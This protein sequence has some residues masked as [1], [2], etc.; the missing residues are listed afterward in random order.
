MSSLLSCRSP[1]RGNLNRQT[2]KQ[3]RRGASNWLDRNGL[4]RVSKNS[5]A[6]LPQSSPRSKASRETMPMSHCKLQTIA[7]RTDSNEHVSFCDWM[8]VL[9]TTKFQ[10]PGLV[11]NAAAI[12]LQRKVF[13]NALCPKLMSPS[14]CRSLPNMYHVAR[15]SLSEASASSLCK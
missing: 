4:D 1:M 12:L 15:I 8:A 9:N 2:T 14:E 10:H 11:T 13:F 6:G 5:P 7:G 3:Q